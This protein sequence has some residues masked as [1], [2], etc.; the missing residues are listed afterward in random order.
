[1]TVA[2]FWAA[3]QLDPASGCWI[4][5]AEPNS[6]GYVWI[7]VDGVNG[8]VHRHAVRLSGRKLPRGFRRVVAHRCDNKRCFNPDHVY[9]ASQSENVR[10]AWARIPRKPL[11]LRFRKPK[12]VPSQPSSDVGR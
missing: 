9:V 4:F 11:A 6:C 2:E 3:A 8:S 5:P 12:R 10:D 7:K 1:M